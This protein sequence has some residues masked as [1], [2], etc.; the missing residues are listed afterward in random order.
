M[1]IAH[2]LPALGRSQ[3]NLT[4]TPAR[5]RAVD[6]IRA[7]GTILV[8]ALHWL[9][10]EATWDGETLAVGNALGHGHAWL[11]TWLNPL[12][13]LFFAA[14]AA[15]GYD[16][17]RR[18]AGALSM[19][20]GRLRGLVWPVGTFLAAWI[21]A[22]L[23]LPLLGLPEQAVRTAAAI[24]I[25]PLWFLP[26]YLVLVALAPALSRAMGRS[27]PAGMGVVTLL[28]LAAA[29]FDAARW[30]TGSL[31]A[32][33]PTL[34]V[35]WAVPFAL[36]MLYARR[37]SA[38]TPIRPAVA[39]AM[40][41]VGALA[42]VALIVVGPYP[43]S[44]IGMPGEAVSNLGP[45]TAPVVTF[46]VAQVGLALLAAPA[47]HR[48]QEHS[49]LLGWVGTHSM[50]IYLWH[51]TAAFAVAGVVLLGMDRALPTPWSDTWWGWMPVFLAGCVAV[52]V[53]LVGLVGLQGRV[54]RPADTHSS[55]GG[56]TPTPRTRASTAV[57]S[58]RPR[59]DGTITA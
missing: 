36:G 32:G 16:L 49:R 27:A 50:P 2:P 38:G 28:A 10:V 18:P 25:Q 29:G 30:A 7:I 37:R 15:A 55:R 24:V 11:L 20:R 17:L 21:A 8:V 31:A 59:H 26:V 19:V 45:P 56:A 9:M 35:G 23:A 3:R 34:V 14:G 44:L 41:A 40:A 58:A 46:A 22:I 52:L 5:D 33:W 57:P 51:L 47:L 53:G 6:G 13:L 43:V 48:L 54:P 42:T 4:P 1:S 12:P 39:L